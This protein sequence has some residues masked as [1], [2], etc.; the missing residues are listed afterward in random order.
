M[1]HGRHRGRP[2]KPSQKRLLSERLPDLRIALPDGEGTLDPRTLFATDVA[3]VWLEIGFGAG[4]HL[5]AQAAAHPEH[6]FMG[7]EPFINGVAALLRSADDQNLTN[8]RIFPDDARLLLAALAPATIGRAFVLFPDPWPK[9]R[10]K[11]RRIVSTNTVPGLARVLED[12]AQL[13]FATDDPDYCRSTL[14]LLWRHA[15]FDWPA[16]RAAD[17]R[18]RP[19]DWPA[20]R[21]EAKARAA[22]R[23]PVFLSFTR[24]PRESSEN[25]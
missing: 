24:R 16:R 9:A 6:G 3:D 14:A 12:G 1:F 15:E 10:H 18:N 8:L 25:P 2:L 4:E 7:C 19:G 11:K 17:W 22:G 20:T 5:A 23:A 13:R 21:Y